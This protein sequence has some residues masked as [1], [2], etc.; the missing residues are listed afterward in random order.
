MHILYKFATRSRP[1]KFKATVENI[2]S[3]AKHHYFQIL[4]SGDTDDPTMH[5]SDMVDWMDNIEELYYVFSESTNKINAINRDINVTN[6]SFGLHN[7][8]ILVNVSD[9]MVFIK[10]GFDLDIIEAFGDNMDQFIH[11]PD[12]HTDTRICSL[13]IMSRQYYN[14]F[15]YI[16]HPDYVSLWCDNEAMEVAQQINRYKYVDKQIFEHRHPAWIGGPVDAHLAHTQKFER[17]D[18]RTYL[19]RKSLGFP[20]HSVY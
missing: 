12:G 2:I 9:D 15:G 20:N 3:L 7:W 16:Y 5:N 1:K 13:S 17:Q 18:H 8:D 11:F 6:T 10:D 4:V 14:R 19:K